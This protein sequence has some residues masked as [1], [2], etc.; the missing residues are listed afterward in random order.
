MKGGSAL[1]VSALRRARREHGKIRRSAELSLRAAS[2]DWKRA[3]EAPGSNCFIGGLTGRSGTSW[4]LRLVGEAMEGKAA[5]IGEHGVFVLSQFRGAA[6][7]FYQ[8]PRGEVT[9]RAYLGYF[10]SFMLDYAYDRHRIY[11]VGGHGL[12]N[13][14]PRHPIRAALDRLESEA[15]AAP[16]LAECQL[17]FGRF[18]SRLMTIAAVLEADT[19]S[20]VSKEPPYGRHATD[21]HALIPDC[22]LVVLARDGRDTALS[23]AKLGW[24]GGDVRRCMD[25]WKAFAGQSL[26]AIERLPETSVLLLRYEDVIED[27]SASLQRVLDFF[28]FGGLDLPSTPPSLE[29]PLRGNTGKWIGKLDSESREYFDRTC[30]ELSRRLGYD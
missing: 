26:E 21:L 19:T 11:G 6:Y 29:P 7:E 30:G 13:W 24:H 2:C 20:W 15:M 25:R 22:R 10:R 27:A 12:R 9:R 1:A 4:L 23:M 8:A 18:Y 3:L 16:T 14:M 5:A 17:C 28:G